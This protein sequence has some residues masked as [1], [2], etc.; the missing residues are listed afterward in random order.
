[1]L[2][3]FLEHEVNFMQRFRYGPQCKQKPSCAECGYQL[4]QGLCNM[5]G[6][7]SIYICVHLLLECQ[8]NSFFLFTGVYQALMTYMQDED[9]ELK[10]VK[11]PTTALTDLEINWFEVIDCLFPAFHDLKSVCGIWMR[12]GKLSKLYPVFIRNFNGYVYTA[13]IFSLKKDLLYSFL[14]A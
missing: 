9:A 12:S 14:S 4:E 7:L 5:E 10:L 8:N 2:L 11:D 1:M 3:F 13:K 6:I